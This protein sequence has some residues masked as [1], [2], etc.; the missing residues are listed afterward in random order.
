MADDVN[1]I[2]ERLSKMN[3]EERVKYL[4]KL[5][6]DAK[7][8][9]Q[10]TEKMLKESQELL[11]RNRTELMRQALLDE[12]K[13]LRNQE[14]KRHFEKERK[15]LT[16]FFKEEQEQNGL[17]NSVQDAPRLPEDHKIVGLYNRIQELKETE[18][19]PA[20]MQNTVHEIRRETAELLSHYKQMPEE[21]K[22]IAD[23]TYRL[24]KELLGENAVDTRKYFP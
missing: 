2:S 1:T 14:E 24:S 7:L 16:K 5:S 11:E 3:P 21:M 8:K 18:H 12:Q 6:E 13:M 9:I 15:E 4:E 10:Q 19:N 20:Y 17:E 23:A 22:E